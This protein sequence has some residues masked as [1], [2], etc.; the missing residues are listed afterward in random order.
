MRRGRPGYREGSQRLQERQACPLL[1]GVA[2]GYR[3]RYGPVQV[4]IHFIAVPDHFERWRETDVPA[5]Q[6]EDGDVRRLS[7]VHQEARVHRRV[8]AFSQEIVTAYVRYQIDFREYG[9]TAA[10]RQRRIEVVIEVDAVLEEVP[11]VAYLVQATD[12]A[13]AGVILT[14]AFR[15]VKQ[16]AMSSTGTVEIPVAACWVAPQVVGRNRPEQSWWQSF[17][18]RKLPRRRNL[19]VL[20]RPNGALEGRSRS[21]RAR[22]AGFSS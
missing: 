15:S 21:R 9:I 10:H 1:K 17:E 12:G 20:I 13:D 3:C 2:Q 18:I 22:C 11:A 6:R 7:R 5:E 14:S 4:S 19:W 8:P 16:L